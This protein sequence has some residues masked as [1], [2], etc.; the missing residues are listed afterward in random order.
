[1]SE[2][3]RFRDASGERWRAYQPPT[4]R[5]Q[6]IEQG[7]EPPSGTGRLGPERKGELW[8]KSAGGERRVL[9]VFPRD[10]RTLPKE[11]LV[12][13]WEQASIIKHGAI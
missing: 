13:L 4:P 10:W 9:L 12:R 1:M 7:I 5:A 3:R 11:A 2:E 6:G 8:F